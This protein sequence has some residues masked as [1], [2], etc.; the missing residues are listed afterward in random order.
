MGCFNPRTHESATVQLPGPGTLYK[1]SI[2]ALMRVRLSNSRPPMES[3]GFNPRTHESATDRITPHL[4][5]W[6]GFNP[7]THESATP[8]G[9]AGAAGSPG[10]NPRTH[11][12]ATSSEGY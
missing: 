2:H 9:S 12:S 8:R 7:R 10:F 11:E 3:T 5:G 4:T 6:G 1:V